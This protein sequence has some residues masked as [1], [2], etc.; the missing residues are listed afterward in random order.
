MT[1]QTEAIVSRS[2]VDGW[3]IPFLWKFGTVVG[4]LIT[5]AVGLLYVKQDSLLYFPGTYILWFTMGHD[6]S[7]GA[8]CST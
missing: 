1:E 4:G 3:V 2:I 7:I 8:L 6:T 5:L